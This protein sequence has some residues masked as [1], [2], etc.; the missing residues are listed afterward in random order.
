MAEQDPPHQ[1]E[2]PVLKL[3]DAVG[4]SVKE[5]RLAPFCLHHKTLIDD[6]ARRIE[7]ADCKATL[8][9]IDVLSM[10]AREE[11]RLDQLRESNARTIAALDEKRR[12][13][14]AH[15]SRFTDV[16]RPLQGQSTETPNA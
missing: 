5:R 7:C 8:D 4:R 15:C 9:P 12:F 6:R 2:R 3:K 11:S 14:C 16:T 1:P 10:L 13:K